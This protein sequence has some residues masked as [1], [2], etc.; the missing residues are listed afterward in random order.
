L[1]LVIRMVWRYASLAFHNFLLLPTCCSLS[2]VSLRVLGIFRFASLQRSDGFGVGK[3]K[4]TRRSFSRSLRVS[5]LSG[6]RS[7]LRARRQSDSL[8]DIA[9]HHRVCAIVSEWSY[10]RQTVHRKSLHQY[11]DC[12]RCDNRVQNSPTSPVSISLPVP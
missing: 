4:V 2:L 11:Y 7:G 10:R 1:A 6:Q 3:A 9:S 5:A 8:L 12:D